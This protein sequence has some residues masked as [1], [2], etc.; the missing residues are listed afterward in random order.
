MLWGAEPDRIA[1]FLNVVKAGYTNCIYGYNEPN[2][3]TES[4]LNAT[5][6]AQKW[7]EVIL[8]L[9]QQGYTDI[10]TP[11]VTSAPSGVDWY[12]DFF[13]ACVGCNFNGMNLHIYATTSGEVINYLNDMHNKFQMPIQVTEFACQSFTGEQQCDSQ[14]TFQFMSE[15][16]QWMDNTPFITKYFAYGVMKDININSLDQLMADDGTPTALG[17]L[18]L[19]EP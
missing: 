8:P 9:T 6:A 2:L 12:H 17:R 1:A 5:F 3:N 7:M 19:G 15:V 18:Y 11:A 13:Q 4:N 16:T 10:Y 14:Q